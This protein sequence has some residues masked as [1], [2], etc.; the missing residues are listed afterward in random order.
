MQNIFVKSALV[1]TAIGATTLLAGCS[2][3][4]SLTESHK[5]ETGYVIYDLKNVK[6]YNALTDGISD[7]LKS[8][9]SKINVS[10]GV[11]PYPLPDKPSHFKMQSYGT[12]S[13]AA[14]AT[15]KGGMLPQTPSCP[16]ALWRAYA[17]DNGFAQYGQITRYWACLFVYKGGYQLDLYTNYSS[18]SGIGSGVGAL[19][20]AIAAPF[21]GTPDKFIPR[22]METIV[23]N[24][25]KTGATLN[26]V[27]SFPDHKWASLVEKKK[28]EKP[29]SK[30]GQS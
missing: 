27:A 7:G 18:N 10:Q 2:G 28:A 15:L 25:K 24:I 23:D 29:K 6:D 12:S 11:A 26:Y 19:G 21:V 4:N 16:D 14:L 13:I 1:A 22:T 8:N 5:Q 9:T 3:L 17:V 30:D 20:A